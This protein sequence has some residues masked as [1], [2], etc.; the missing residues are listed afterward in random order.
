M[1]QGSETCNLVQ[2]YDHTITKYRIK[3]VNLCNSHKSSYTNYLCISNPINISLN[4]IHNLYNLGKIFKDFFEFEL[5][6]SQKQPNSYT[7]TT[8]VS[9]AI[10]FQ[11]F[12]PTLV[13]EVSFTVELYCETVYHHH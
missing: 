2:P 13:R 8:Y 10:L 5:K 11:E 12:L 6:A 7:A 3:S 1:K 4:Y 9:S